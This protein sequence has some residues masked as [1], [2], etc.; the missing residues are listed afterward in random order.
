MLDVGKIEGTDSNF[1]VC[2]HF[3]GTVTKQ[4]PFNSATSH[5]AL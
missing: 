1:I 4:P 2:I 5:T 3:A